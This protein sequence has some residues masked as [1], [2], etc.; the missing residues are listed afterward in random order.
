MTKKH[1]KELIRIGTVVKLRDGR[2]AVAMNGINPKDDFDTYKF[3]GL[4][5]LTSTVSK[6]EII[7]LDAYNDHLDYKEG[8][9]LLSSYD[10]MAVSNDLVSF[11]DIMR[12][13]FGFVSGDDMHWD[14]ER[15]EIKEVTMEEVEEKFGCKVK[16]VKEE[17]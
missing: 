2:L 6:G 3:Y 10:I 16:I 4:K 14:W 8:G 13:M 1:L 11:K 5:E 9:G 15:E 17:N 7:N 12:I